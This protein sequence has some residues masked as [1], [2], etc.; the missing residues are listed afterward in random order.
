MRIEFDPSADALYLRL[1]FGDVAET[2][3]LSDNIYLDVD[4]DGHVLGAEFVNAAEFFLN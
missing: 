3:E 4:S 1:R 2:V